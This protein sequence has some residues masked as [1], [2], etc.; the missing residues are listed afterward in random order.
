MCSTLFP[1]VGGAQQVLPAA[2][3]SDDAAAAAAIESL[4]KSRFKAD[5]PGA[6]IIATRNGKTVFRKA[7]G[8]ADIAAKTPLKPDD[9]LRIGSVTK[10]FTAV[11][12]LMLADEGKLALGDDVS[13]YVPTFTSKSKP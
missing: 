1:V 9:V 13:K 12:I 8:L 5:E 7:Y 4:A 11:G 10:Q 2:T 3:P 6:T